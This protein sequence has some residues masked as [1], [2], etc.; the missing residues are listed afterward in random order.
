VAGRDLRSPAGFRSGPST[1]S[2]VH[3]QLG[4]AGGAFDSAEKKF[5]DDI[6]L[7]QIVR[8]DRDREVQQESLNKM[9][10]WARVWGM[11][12]NIKKCMVMHYGQRNQNN[13]YYMDGEKL[14]AT[15]EERDIGVLASNTLKPEAQGAKAARTA[16]T[17]LS[18]LSRAFHF[19]DRHTFIRLYTQYVLPHLEFAI[20]AWSPWL[21]KDK[22]TLE[23]LQR[24][25]VGMVSGLKGRTYE[26]R[27]EELDMTTLEEGRH[28]L[29]MIQTF[30]IIGGHD[31]VE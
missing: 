1:I 19:R 25:A 24:R 15:R 9:T 8:N 23:K 6:K 26:E 21:E 27:P 11:S 4:C 31:A 30:K 14:K 18:Q 22:E 20:Q 17:V 7:G 2:G 10:E 16:S 12:F 3:K 5:A 13:D 29:D 28:Q